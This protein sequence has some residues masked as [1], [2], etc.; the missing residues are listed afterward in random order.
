[1]T[2]SPR[3]TTA[4]RKAL[5]AAIGK[6]IDRLVSDGRLYLYPEP[7]LKS[8]RSVYLLQLEH[9]VLECSSCEAFFKGVKDA[10][11]AYYVGKAGK[12]IADR[13]AQ[14]R[15]YSSHDLKRGRASAVAPAQSHQRSRAASHQGEYTH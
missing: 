5:A 9:A 7:H 13:L 6:E 3:F 14:H 12:G 11:A 2:V 1:M 4:D 10:R 15:E 8:G